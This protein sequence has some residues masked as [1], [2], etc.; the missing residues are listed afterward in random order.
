MRD[1]GAVLLLGWDRSDVRFVLPLDTAVKM[2]DRARKFGLAEGGRPDL[3]GL[4][5][6]LYWCLTGRDAFPAKGPARPP[7]LRDRRPDLPRDRILTN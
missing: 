5:G 3:D 1:N 2:F 4:G 7:T 6:V